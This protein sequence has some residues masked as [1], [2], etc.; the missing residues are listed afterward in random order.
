[1]YPMRFLRL[2]RVLAAAVV[3]AGAVAP[4]SEANGVRRLDE[5]ADEVLRAM[6]DYYTGLESFSVDVATYRVVTK[7][8]KSRDAIVL[9]TVAVRRP[10]GFSLVQTGADGELTV[11]SDG[12][13]VTTYLAEIRQ[14][15]VTPAPETFE[16]VARDSSQQPMRL[17]LEQISV[18]GALIL[19]DPYDWLMEDVASVEYVALEKLDGGAYHHVVLSHKDTDWNLWIASGGMPLLKMMIPDLTRAI[20]AA[21]KDSPELADVKLDVTMLFENWSVNAEIPDSRFA[22]APPPGARRVDRFSL[23]GSPHGMLGQKVPPLKLALLGGGEMDLASHRG[24]AVVVLEFWASWSKACR[25]RL[26]LVAKVASRFADRGVVFC[27][28]NQGEDEKAVREFLKEI[29]LDALKVT[30]AMDRDSEAARRCGVMSVP[31]T[32][33]IGRDGKVRAAHVGES[34]DL[35]KELAKELE[36]LVRPKRAA[37]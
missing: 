9:Q 18:L 16:H 28:V 29:G 26:P 3:L 37:K 21:A 11:K 7:D 5:K 4:L 14:Y 32:I 36:A 17:A 24:K 25:R 2:A 22:F 12:A 6:A 27:A 13:A 31:Q 15:I 30:V 23:E 10:N 20:A 33:V 34:A 35:A 1:M 8:E 19:G